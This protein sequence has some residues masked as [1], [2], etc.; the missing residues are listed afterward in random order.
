MKLGKFHLSWRLIAIWAGIFILCLLIWLFG[1]YLAFADAQPFASIS[2]RVVA[3]LVVLLTALA[4]WGIRRWL[5]NK[6][7]AALAAD[8]ASQQG[9]DR[10]RGEQF[11]L[12]KR[13]A[14]AVQVLKTR[15][16][17]RKSLYQLPWYTIVGPPGSG[18]ST[19]LQN[20]GL[21]FPLAEK[22][23]I[24][25]VQGVGGTRSCDWWFTSDAVFLDTAGRFT[26][27]DSDRNVDQAA[28]KEFLGLLVKYRPR[29]PLN[30]AI[31]AVSASDIMTLDDT[32]LAELAATVRNRIEEMQQHTNS[33]IP[34][35]MVF[36][37][38]DLVSGFI[39]FFEDL[40]RDERAQVW[41][42]SFDA[43]ES[44]DGKAID[45]FESEF[46]LLTQQVRQKWLQRVHTETDERR[47]NAIFA[48]PSEFNTLKSQLQRFTERAL[49]GSAYGDLIMLRGVYFTSGTQEGTPVD[50]MLGALSRRF[51]IDA[52]A[53]QKSHSAVRTFFV[54]RLLNAV[55]IPESGI[56]ALAPAS[57]KRRRLVQAGI[58]LGGAVCTLLI[59]LLLGISYQKNSSYLQRV[60]TEIAGLDEVRARARN[61][62]DVSEQLNRLHTIVETAK[63]PEQGRPISMRLGLLQVPATLDAAES[64]YRRALSSQLLPI[65]AE[66]LRE[67]IL[68]TSAEPGALYEYLRAYLMLAQPEHLDKNFLSAIGEI[69]W[70]R[71]VRGERQMRQQ[72]TEHFSRLV[73]A[74]QDFPPIIANER[75]LRTARQTLVRASLPQLAYARL[76]GNYG[77][78]NWPDLNL[79]ESLGLSAS[80]M[81][82]R[83][84]GLELDQEPLAA[85]YTQ[86]VFRSV[87]DQGA[88]QVVASLLMDS[89][90]LGDQE[91]RLP[92]EDYLTEQL[93]KL[94]E[95]DYIAQWNVLI[96]DISLR[97]TRSLSELQDQL[98]LLTS[99]A[100]PLRA[101]LG[102]ID[103]HTRIEIEAES[104]D[105]ADQAAGNIAEAAKRKAGNTRLG[106]LLGTNQMAGGDAG[107][108][109]YMPGQ[110]ITSAFE[111]YHKLAAGQPGG[112]PID[113]MTRLLSDYLDKVSAL[114]P[115][116]AGAS[117][118]STQAPQ[119][120]RAIQAEA[121][122][123][124]D[125][126]GQMLAQITGSGTKISGQLAR[127]QVAKQFDSQVGQQAK[128][129]CANRYPFTAG[130]SSEIPL[131]DFAR[132]FAAGGL[133]D[134]FIKGDIGRLIDT[135]RARWR[136]RPGPDGKPPGSA[137]LL[138]K[139]QRADEIKNA[140]FPAGGSQLK[141]PFVLELLSADVTQLILAVGESQ[142]L[143]EQNGLRRAELS[144][145]DGR[146]G[147]VA[148]QALFDDGRSETFDWKGAWA[149][150]RML[151][152]SEY[153]KESDGSLNVS[154]ASQ[155]RNVEFRIEPGALRNPFGEDLL[156]GFICD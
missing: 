28:W 46:E 68:A 10:V 132:L 69:E 137:S 130:A 61:L 56:A 98:Y 1:P 90:V 31:V 52:S 101:L 51:G 133:Y 30:G 124:P 79:A 87:V 7:N 146:V 12:Q 21:D 96:D 22:F 19:L 105:L 138:Q 63:N 59:L 154:L 60:S 106:R 9:E 54:E 85:L 36:T 147:G 116:A 88:G 29:Q 145:P 5:E 99:S 110:A 141:I 95:R 11:E 104:D 35:Y 135:S 91:K 150:F 84:S 97:P 34:V 73:N 82:V 140:Y 71:I 13:F 27:Q 50:R 144:W 136:W 129:S 75:L 153:S 4:I 80:D 142:V 86:P 155:G 3:T 62:R 32:R 134:Q 65:F 111:S 57:I 151:D 81:F 121:Q 58:Y 125:Q 103:E 42:V 72:L 114:D 18:K 123:W 44:F 2:G 156:Q 41:G 26:T 16:S 152:S 94:Y 102:L 67:R 37:K 126:T 93:I 14:E 43:E 139:L 108:S 74:E 148:I 131:S 107:E 128:N 38:M 120:I 89:W 66:H 55:L 40:D 92:S 48:F 33:R 83:K 78:Q 39:E 112:T 23:G 20:S 53:A 76:Q 45:R 49:K 143:L 113:T 149:L 109:E 127:S 24:H 115:A 117:S 122:R 64:A 17:G 25:A 100:S 119:V 70:R 15:G 47:R 8:L 118:P 6:R 77:D